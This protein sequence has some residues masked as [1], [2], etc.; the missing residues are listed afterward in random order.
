MVKCLNNNIGGTRGAAYF[1]FLK[2]QKNRKYYQNISALTM[3][4]LF[5]FLS[6]SLQQYEILYYLKLDT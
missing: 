3:I 2:F 1:Y 6:I 5:L 4:F